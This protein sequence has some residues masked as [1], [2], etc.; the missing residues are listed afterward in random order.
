MFGECL[1][2]SPCQSVQ[3]LPDRS[4]EILP[5]TQQTLESASYDFMTFVVDIFLFFLF[6]L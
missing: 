2:E 3:L 6:C 5:E 4:F 1:L